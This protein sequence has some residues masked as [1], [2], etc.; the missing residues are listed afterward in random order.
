M[1]DKL[2]KLL[3]QALTLKEIRGA[4]TDELKRLERQLNHGQEL[5]LS[6]L[7][8]RGAYEVNA[9]SAA[10]LAP[11]SNENFAK[12]LQEL[13]DSGFEIPIIVT[14]IGSN[15]SIVVCGYSA[16]G[17][18]VRFNPIAERAKSGGLAEPVNVLIVDVKGSASRVVVERGTM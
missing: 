3:E 2:G 15:G 5:A 7:R 10:S 8:R 14:A 13:I 9:S 17:S 11:T 12:I 4:D 1:L 18:G 16:D 6:E